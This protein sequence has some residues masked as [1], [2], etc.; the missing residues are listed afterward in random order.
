MSVCHCT[1]VKLDLVA[2]FLHI[3]ITEDFTNTKPCPKES[4]AVLDVR[5]FDGYCI[6]LLGEHQP[7]N[8]RAPLC[9]GYRNQ[10]PP[11]TT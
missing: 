6:S 8:R 1:R 9:S 3:S 7:I 2:A 11:F 10:I 4:L 5:F